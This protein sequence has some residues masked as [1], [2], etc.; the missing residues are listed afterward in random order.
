MTSFQTITA[1]IITTQ[2]DSSYD[3]ADTE[4]SRK[5]SQDESQD[6]ISWRICT[7]GLLNFTPLKIPGHRRR[8]AFIL[9]QDSRISEAVQLKQ[10]PKVG[11]R[12]TS[13]INGQCC[14]LSNILFSY[15]RN[16][17]TLRY[18]GRL[19]SSTLFQY[20]LRNIQITCQLRSISQSNANW[21]DNAAARCIQPLKISSP[22][23]SFTRP[24]RLE[25]VV[26]S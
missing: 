23:P 10:L 18:P 5:P 11:L 3:T 17:A 13:S 12:S 14:L 6:E 2:L 4:A 24:I 15:D 8:R 19:S 26:V 21:D 25:V 22:I 20:H 1:D 9:A 16:A 7:P